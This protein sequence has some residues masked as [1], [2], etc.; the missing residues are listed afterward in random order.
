[1]TKPDENRLPYNS[2]GQAF[3][4]VFGF[5]TLPELQADRKASSPVNLVKSRSE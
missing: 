4:A 5:E 1:M 3:D 2:T